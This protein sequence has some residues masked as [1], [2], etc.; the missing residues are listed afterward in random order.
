MIMIMVAI[1]III[2]SIIIIIITITATTAIVIIIIII[3]IITVMM[4]FIIPA[5]DPRETI[6]RRRTSDMQE[7]LTGVAEKIPALSHMRSRRRRFCSHRG[8]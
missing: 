3:V 4:L 7:C 2:I 6:E 8:Q 5:T 1:I